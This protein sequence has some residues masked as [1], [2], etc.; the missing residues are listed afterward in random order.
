MRIITH[1]AILQYSELHADAQQALDEWYIKTE[2][3][4]WDCFSDIKQT[5]NSVDVA[6]DKRYVF[7]VK[8]NSYRV[9]ALILFVPKI[10][11]IRFIGTH[12][13]YTK[14]KDCSKI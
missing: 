5:F 14:I 9:I 8:G 13:E 10:V 2:K 12:A 7:N 11:Y 1:K 3:S 6:G 4:Q